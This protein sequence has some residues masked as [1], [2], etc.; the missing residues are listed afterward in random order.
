MANKT[1]VAT[2]NGRPCDVMIPVEEYA[3]LKERNRQAF[4]AGETPKRFLAGIENR[5]RKKK[6]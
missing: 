3:R 1:G 4:P 2:K 5:A 6:R